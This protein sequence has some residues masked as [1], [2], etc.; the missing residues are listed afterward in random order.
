ML[1]EATLASWQK[2]SLLTG[3]PLILQRMKATLPKTLFQ[4]LEL[5]GEA[6]STETQNDIWTLPVFVI[7]D[8]LSR[9]I[10]TLCSS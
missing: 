5:T 9:S 3:N 7:D 4:S 2:E 8:K 10:S 6:L 1:P